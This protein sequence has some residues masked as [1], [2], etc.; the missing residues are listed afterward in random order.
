MSFPQLVLCSKAALCGGLIAGITNTAY[1]SLPR[2]K[3]ECGVCLARAEKCEGTKFWN[4]SSTLQWFAMGSLV[5]SVASP[6][7]IM[8]RKVCA[9]MYMEGG[10]RGAGSFPG[11]KIRNARK[12]SLRKTDK[13]YSLKLEYPHPECAFFAS[14]NGTNPFRGLHLGPFEVEIHPSPVPNYDM[15]MSSDHQPPFERFFGGLSMVRHPK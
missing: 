1:Q 15:F 5:T 9:L 3:S 4:V 10:T 7:F 2:R 13:E 12:C 6:I 8:V 11:I 14:R